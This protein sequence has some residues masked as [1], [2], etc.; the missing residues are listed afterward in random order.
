MSKNKGIIDK[1]KI[2]DNVIV[3]NDSMFTEHE[4][5]LYETICFVSYKILMEILTILTYNHWF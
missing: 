1:A 5:L 3:K 4:Y 2:V